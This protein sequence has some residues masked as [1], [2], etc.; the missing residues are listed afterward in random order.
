MSIE[1]VK[2]IYGQF[3]NLSSGMGRLH[4]IISKYL[5]QRGY[6]QMKQRSIDN[7]DK[8]NSNI[9]IFGQFQTFILRYI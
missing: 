2:L 3:Q 8:G 4:I 9:Y 6:S 1:I 7:T 5:F